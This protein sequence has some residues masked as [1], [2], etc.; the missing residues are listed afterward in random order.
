MFDALYRN[1]TPT[2]KIIM[3]TTDKRDPALAVE[4]LRRT[5]IYNKRAILDKLVAIS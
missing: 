5:R 1:T 2:T 4:K 3:P